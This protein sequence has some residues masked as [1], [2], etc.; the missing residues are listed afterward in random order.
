MKRKFVERL[1]VCDFCLRSE[2]DMLDIRETGDD[3]GIMICGDCEE[4][5]AQTSVTK[6]S[7]GGPDNTTEKR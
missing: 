3:E 2:I 5:Y 7:S 4:K 6:K 1:K